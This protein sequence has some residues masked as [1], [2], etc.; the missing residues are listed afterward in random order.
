MGKGA[1]RHE[2]HGGRGYQAREKLPFQLANGFLGSSSLKGGYVRDSI[3][4][5]VLRV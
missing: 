5:R 4:F 3:G 1:K 2:R